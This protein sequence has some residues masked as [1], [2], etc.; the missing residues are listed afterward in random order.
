MAGGRLS[1]CALTA[2]N[3]MLASAKIEV[4]VFVISRN[5]YFFAVALAIAVNVDV[6]IIWA[7]L[8]G[9]P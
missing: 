8:A 3:V 2:I 4:S 1:A 9:G 7:R 6:C 5:R